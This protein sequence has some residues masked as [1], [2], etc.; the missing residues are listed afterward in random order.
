MLKAGDVG[1]ILVVF[2]EERDGNALVRLPNGSKTSLPFDCL[3]LV[4]RGEDLDRGVTTQDLV[5]GPLLAPYRRDG[6]R[7][8]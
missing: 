7:E 2:I 5:R 4:A 3:D 8:S 6:A 1:T